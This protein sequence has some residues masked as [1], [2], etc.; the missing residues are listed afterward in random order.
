MSGGPLPDRD[1]LLW[2]LDDVLDH[3]SPVRPV[4]LV[5]LD[6]VGFKEYN[7][8]FG[9]P[10]GDAM[11]KHLSTKLAQTVAASRASTA[12][13]AGSGTAYRLDGDEFAALIYADEDPGRLADRFASALVEEGEGFA[14]APC[15][16]T[17]LVPTEARTPSEALRVANERMYAL[18]YALRPAV[19]A[20][21][22]S[23]EVLMDALAHKGPDRGDH[24]HGLTELAEAIARKLGASFEELERVR[25]AAVLHD[26]GKSA[27]PAALLQK[28]SELDEE[29]REFVQRHP[30]IGERILHAAPALHRVAR[31]IRSS[32]ERFDGAGYP[33]RLSG[34]EI[35]LG[36]RIISVCDAFDAMISNRAYRRARTVEEALE[37]LRQNS[38]SQFDP[39]VVDAFCAVMEE[40]ERFFLAA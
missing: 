29:E 18:K 9:R 20:P 2:D 19:T 31:L 4:L 5:L 12:G 40:R 39:A 38:G 25:I 23:G 3:A 37:E 15:F 6:L 34:S 27:L 21:A 30:L 7:D 33:D 1:R 26:I 32:H 28:D 10:A 13:G 11:L 35:P 24:V 8:I 36:A 16:G 17:A 22:A 14:I